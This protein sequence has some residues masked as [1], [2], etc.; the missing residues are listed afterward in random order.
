MTQ[1]EVGYGKP[2]KK[3]RFQKGRSGNA[4]GR[5]KGAKNF[6]TALQDALYEEVF[7][8]E[9]GR[10]RKIS[11]LQA[12]VTQLVNR[13]AGGDLKAIERVSKLTLLLEEKESAD[14]SSGVIDPRADHS[15]LETLTK[16]LRSPKDV[17]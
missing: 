11:K 9:N 17:E 7:V 15:L 8:T 12:V 13:A 5:P 16:R 6:L 1:Y 4:A 10:Q 3:T 14:T 2:P